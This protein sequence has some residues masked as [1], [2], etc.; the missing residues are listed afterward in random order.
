LATE[1]SPKPGN[2]RDYSA[3]NALKVTPV[4]NVGPFSAL[5]IRNFRFLLSG[6]VLS[7]AAQWIQQVT[8]SWLVYNLTGSGTI[9][10]TINLVR[11]VASLSMIPAAGLLVDRLDR[12]KLMLSIN[13]WLFTI[14]LVL[15]L[16]LV[17][18]HSQI[19]YL[20]I[21]AFLGGITMTTDMAL[22]QVVVFDLVPR[23]TAPNALALIQTGWGLMR[24]FGP[25]I[26]G[27][28][29]LW[30]G[31]GGNFLFQAGAYALIAFS[32]V[33]IQF[34]KRK[35]ST[36]SSSPIQNIRE[37]IQYVTKSRMTRTFMLMGFIIPFFIVP[38]FIVLPPIYAEDV[39]HGGPDTLGI[40]MSSVG[41]GSIAGGIFTASLRRF[42]R[43]GLVQLAAL[44]LLS[45]SLVGFAFSKNQW[46]AMP[47]LA[48]SGFFEIIFL[49]TNQTLLQLSI[50]DQL[51]GR[52]T[53]VVNLNAALSPLGGLIAGAGS[54]FFGGPQIITVI[55]CCIGML[56][57]V[58]I[59]FASSTVRNYRLSQGIIS[60]PT[61]TSAP[62]AKPQ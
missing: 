61:G 42:E 54:D 22:R 6:T 44:F 45:L 32:I 41:I 7:N 16:V 25:G 3:N 57:A 34:P 62:I 23:P 19:L 26:G 37:G 8:L 15:G 20:F 46:M 14:T 50:P 4:S 49:I 43:R 17:F 30:F 2:E 52:V 1:S 40:L 31:P 12:R 5:H 56:L 38:I 36:T 53:S 21:F 18:G 39:F 10:G 55:L 51:R 28:L 29:I 11:A 47:F 58:I 60:T 9:L 35:N 13:I 33:Q 59:F 27:F 24:S 48:A